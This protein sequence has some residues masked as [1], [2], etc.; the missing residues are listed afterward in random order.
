MTKEEW[1]RR[2]A[3][4]IA[5]AER[6]L[7]TDG[8]LTPIF[9]VHSADAPRILS[10]PF[11]DDES[12][13]AMIAMVRLCAI[14]QQ[15]TAV[16][17]IVEAWCSL[18]T[19]SKLARSLGPANAR[20]VVLAH[21]AYLDESGQQRLMSRLHAIIRNDKG[22][23]TG[24]GLNELTGDD[25]MDGGAMANLLPPADLPDVVRKAAQQSVSSLLDKMK[26]H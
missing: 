18:P 16:S 14:A 12:K 5:F 15:A 8:Q 26:L 21:C 1:T 10:V 2:L 17:M 20:E 19:T 23:V 7:T 4:D 24:I 11:V 6:I 13:A 22:K 25:E 3:R 9:V